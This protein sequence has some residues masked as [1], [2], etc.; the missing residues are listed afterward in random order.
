MRLSI[1]LGLGLGLAFFSVSLNGQATSPQAARNPPEATI[2]AD[3]GPR[4]I[5]PPASYKFPSGQ[6]YVY[7]VEWHL[8]SAGTATVRVDSD[9]SQHR[10]TA[11]AESA[12]VVNT[13]FKVH[14]NFEALFDPH[15]FCS[16]AI[17]KHTE[18]GP[19]RRDTMVKFDYAQK[20]ALLEEK[21]LKTGEQK[22]EQT[23]IPGCV[24]D[25]ITGFYY[26]ASAPLEP[27]NHTVF[28]INGGGKTTIAEAKVEAR[29]QIKVPAGTFQTVR[30]QVEAT[31][32]PLQGKG[33][34]LVWYSDDAN[35]TPVQM[36]SKLGWGTLL[37][38]LQKIDRSN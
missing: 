32:G 38:R 27:G 22:H 35:H 20:K 4:I 11:T 28:P 19:H 25:V 2:S 30:V 33:S 36:R 12:G 1:W 16:L 8:F 9:G 13:L 17:N 26:L 7:A 5:P 31:S 18:E 14:D 24:T 10:V 37:F 21:N 6:T 23:D 3:P 34:V 15:T 29:E